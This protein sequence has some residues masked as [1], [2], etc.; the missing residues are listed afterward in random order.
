M[1]IECDNNYI[2]YP[3]D[4]TRDG[5]AKSLMGLSYPDSS[6]D[7]ML[8]GTS[9]FMTRRDNTEAMVPRNN[10]GDTSDSQTRLPV[11]HLQGARKPEHGA[12]DC[13]SGS[14][15][16]PDLSDDVSDSS[17]D[18][19]EGGREDKEICEAFGGDM[20]SC[21]E[22]ISQPNQH[23]EYI[24]SLIQDSILVDAAVGSEGDISSTMESKSQSVH[25]TESLDSNVPVMRLRGG[26]H[27]INNFC[28]QNGYIYIFKRDQI[29]SV[30]MRDRVH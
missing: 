8:G 16:M 5:G 20:S 25:Q 14:D 19:S 17:D 1:V 7:A 23:P 22:Y 29:Q 26:A 27:R 9:K 24:I 13:R 3:L 28:Y 10:D 11:L 12:A 15:N 4:R 21:R 2:D 6:P 30:L 18:S